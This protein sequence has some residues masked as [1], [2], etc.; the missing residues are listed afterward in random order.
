[1]IVAVDTSALAKLLVEE[2]E[3][4][5]LREHLAQRDAAGDTIAISTIAVTELR[6]L[7]IRLDI[8]PDHVEPVLRPFR[9]I[10]LT[11]GILQL[12]GRLAHRHLGTLDAI[13]IATALS[14]EAQALITFDTR[15]TDAARLEGLAVEA[16]GVA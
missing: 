10:R 6:R 15:Q 3:S 5:T 13:H 14:I 7:A 16:P 9:V 11:E 8:E 2:A 4:A 1:M 12:A